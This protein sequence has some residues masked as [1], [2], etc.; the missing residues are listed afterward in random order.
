MDEEFLKV[1]EV[2]AWLRVSHDS[3]YRLIKAGHL[4]AIRVGRDYRITESSAK[5]FVKQGGVPE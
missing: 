4:D 2:A 5:G 3:V 1:A